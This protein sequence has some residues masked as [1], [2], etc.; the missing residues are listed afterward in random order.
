MA[1]HKHSRSGETEIEDESHVWG[2][3]LPG[4]I[5][6]AQT[7]KQSGARGHVFTKSVG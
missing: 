3:S 4:F 5:I 6:S 1:S 7:V 2:D